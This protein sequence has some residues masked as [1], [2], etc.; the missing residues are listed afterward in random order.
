M[1]G[2][3]GLSS[4]LVDIGFPWFGRWFSGRRTTTMRKLSIPVAKNCGCFMVSCPKIHHYLNDKG[5]LL[6]ASRSRKEER[7]LQ[8]TNGTINTPTALLPTWLFWMSCVTLLSISC[9]TRRRG[10]RLR[11]SGTIR[12]VTQ[13][14]NLPVLEEVSVLR[15][16]IADWSCALPIPCG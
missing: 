1:V 2:F 13:Y 14:R 10:Q 15:W 8:A 16:R 7:G 11:Q 5:V 4:G 6:F 12:L 9:Q 3:S